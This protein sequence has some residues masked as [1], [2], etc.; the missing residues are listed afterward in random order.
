MIK[1]ISA[2]PSAIN[3]KGFWKATLYSFGSFFI[4]WLLIW[5]INPETAV[6]FGKFVWVIPVIND[7]LVFLKKYFD[8]LLK[9]SVSAKIKNV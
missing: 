3:N 9:G 8:A 1:V 6:V 7:I 4:G 5:L 2:V